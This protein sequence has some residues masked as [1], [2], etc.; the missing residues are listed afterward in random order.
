MLPRTVFKIG[1]VTWNKGR[2][3][4]VP[5][6]QEHKDKISATLKAKGIKP[7]VMCGD[8]NPMKRPEQRA[9]QSGDGNVMKRLEQRDRQSKNNS[10]KKSE[11]AAKVSKSMKQLYIVRPELKK[12]GDSNPMK[13]SEV[14]AKV[15]AKISGE[16]NSSK[17]PENRLKNS[18]SH[19]GLQ[20]GEKNGNWIDGC[21]QIRSINRRKRELGYKSLNEP[22][23][24]SVGHHWDK[25]EVLH[26][27]RK[28]HESI[29]HRQNDSKSMQKMNEA[30]WDWFIKEVI[31][32][33]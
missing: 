25:I 13:R 8:V 14:V 20:V 22:F 4:A 27:P 7:P 33:D 31:E 16:N 30:A 15:V 3:D 1:H 6:S 24:G 21:G 12:M 5:R 26:I 10:M 29:P 19:M 17:R 28:L 2:K 11:V 32:I 18:K 9:R 23:E